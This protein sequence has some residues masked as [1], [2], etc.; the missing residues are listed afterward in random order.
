MYEVQTIRNGC[1]ASPLPFHQFLERAGAL[2]WRNR[3]FTKITVL[4]PCITY[5]SFFF[6]EKKWFLE[7]VKFIF[8]I[9]RRVD[10]TC[11]G[12]LFRLIRALYHMFL[13]F[14][15]FT[16]LKFRPPSN[17]NQGLQTPPKKII[18]F[19]NIWKRFSMKIGGFVKNAPSYL[20]GQSDSNKS[21]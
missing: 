3:Y 2:L 7:H 10:R 8:Y 18:D 11:L 6:W 21:L 17:A 19:S 5:E 9:N 4:P 20:P 13:R 1:I 14:F 15:F 16:N 12:L